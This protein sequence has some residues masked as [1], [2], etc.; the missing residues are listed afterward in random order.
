VFQRRL[1]FTA[2]HKIGVDVNLGH[3]VDDDGDALALAISEDVIEQGSFSRAEEAR[4]D[5]DREAVEVRIVHSWVD[6]IRYDILLHN[7]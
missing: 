6:L 2:T 1:R 7:N 5:G 3:V 4:Q